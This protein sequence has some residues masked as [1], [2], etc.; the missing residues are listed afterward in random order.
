MKEDDLMASNEVEYVIVFDK[1]FRHGDESSR[2][3]VS[4][5]ARHRRVWL[6]V[7]LVTSRCR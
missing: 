6:T 2:L 7:V 1:L 4:P 5:V 3:Y